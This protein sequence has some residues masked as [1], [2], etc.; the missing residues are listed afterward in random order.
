MPVLGVKAMKLPAAVLVVLVATAGLAVPAQA[1]TGCVAAARQHGGGCGAVAFAHRGAHGSGVDENT[2]ESL[3]AAYTKHA[4]METDV[5]LTQDRGL[6]VIHDDTLDRTTNCKGDVASWQMADI[7]Q[8]CR[9]EPNGQRLPVFSRFVQAL[10]SN[11]GQRVMVEIKGDGWYDNE[12]EALKRLRSAAAQAGVLKRVYF[13]HDADTGTIEALRDTV[14]TAR[15]A[16]KPYANDSVTPARAKEL[17][18]DAVVAL[19]EQWTSRAKVRSFKSRGYFAW[20]R[21]VN[22]E[23]GWKRLIR[24]GVTGIMTDKPGAFRAVCTRMGA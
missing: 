24:R 1:A 7:Q 2:V 9:T 23:A 3:D 5:R 14:P 15:T 22:D 10:A 4:W 11:P 16:W 18:V 20:S 19:P 21:L 17:S 8:D 13:T 12:N 6:L